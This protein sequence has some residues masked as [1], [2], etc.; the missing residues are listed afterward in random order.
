MRVLIAQQESDLGGL[1]KRSLE[2]AGAEVDLVADA[3]EAVRALNAAPYGVLIVTLSLQENGAL[4]VADYAA[5]RRPDARVIFVTNSTF[6]SDGSIFRHA[7]N[8]ATMVPEDTPPEDL[9]ALAE[10]YATS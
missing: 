9:V 7:A 3:E 6:F 2:R 4:A 5:Y 1:W 8:A 10:H